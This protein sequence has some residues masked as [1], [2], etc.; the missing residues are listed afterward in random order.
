VTTVFLI[1][2]SAR[3]RDRLENLLEQAGADV[4][5]LAT[6]SSHAAGDLLEF[7][8]VV[9]LDASD[10]AA[11]ELLENLRSEGFLNDARVL[12]LANSHSPAWTSRAL[13][14]GVRAVLPP[15]SNARELRAA[16]DAVAQD[17]L[18]LHPSEL[19][20]AEVGNEA[21]LS[22]LIEPLTARER[23]V[24]QVLAQGGGNKEIASRLKISEHTAKFHVASILGKLGASTR[25][26]A[27]SMA[28]RRG[29]V[30]L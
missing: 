12:L 30:L 3:E 2:A 5:G 6:D 9:L 25:T 28:L 11:E 18:V 17:L 21:E 4:V 13:R 19:R 15:D 24:L 1:A 23:E 27:V 29:L 8:E 26:E 14:L 16:L 7:A 20:G 10:D 22:D